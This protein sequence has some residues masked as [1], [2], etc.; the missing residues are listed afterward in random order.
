MVKK[1]E[2]KENQTSVSYWS[3]FTLSAPLFQREGKNLDLLSVLT[4]FCL[5]LLYNEVYERLIFFG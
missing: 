1:S 2:N 3:A 4:H 5:L